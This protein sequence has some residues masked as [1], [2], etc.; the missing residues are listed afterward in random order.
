[1]ADTLTIT[2]NRTGKAYDIPIVDG[3][4]HAIDL[5]QIEASRDDVGLLSSDPAFMNT[6]STR[7]AIGLIDGR[8]RW[9]SSGSRSRTTTS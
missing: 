1:M 9:S 4:I 5:R 8:S 7:S 3:A 2:D 6:A